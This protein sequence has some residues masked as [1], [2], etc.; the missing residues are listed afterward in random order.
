MK[1]AQLIAAILSAALAAVMSIGLSCMYYDI[2]GPTNYHK[3]LC[4]QK[5]NNS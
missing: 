2:Y 3:D 1:D 5:L 4:E